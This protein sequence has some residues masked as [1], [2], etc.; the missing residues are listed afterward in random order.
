MTQ[1]FPNP[2][3]RKKRKSNPGHPYLAWL[4][5]QRCAICSSAP[6]VEAVHVEG[7]LSL[8]THLTLPRRKHQAYLSAI[9]ACAKCHRTG[10]GSIH[11][12]GEKPFAIYQ[13]GTSDALAR[14]AHA[15]LITWVRER[16]E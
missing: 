8:K 16:R 14:L 11:E 1:A 4:K 2:A 7:P 15:Y 3:P 5:D 13:F 6:P 12:L 10:P 9:P